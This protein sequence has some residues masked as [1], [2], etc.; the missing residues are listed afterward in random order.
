MPERRSTKN[1]VAE[2]KACRVAAVNSITPDA[3]MRRQLSVIPSETS[4]GRM[5]LADLGSRTRF[6]QSLQRSAGNSALL[7]STP[8]RP[9]DGPEIGRRVVGSS[10]PLAEVQRIPGV[11]DTVS[12]SAGVQR[13]P[14]GGAGGAPSA[15]SAA[16]TAAAR[17]EVELLGS[18]L[19]I[20]QMNL[21]SFL[22]DANSDITNIR[23]YFK[24]LNDVFARCHQHYALVIAQA[25]AEAQTEQAW[26]DFASGVA[27]GA[28]V[29]LISEAVIAGRA[30]EKAIESVTEVAAE[31]V[32]GGIGSFAK[33]DV[34]KPALSADLAPALKQVATLAKL[35]E[36]NAA[37]L[38]K[39]ISGLL[40]LDPIVQSERL[41][42]ELR[43]AEAGGARRMSDADVQEMHLRLMRFEVSSSQSD[44]V[45][46][47]AVAAFD[48]LRQRYMGLQPPSDERTEQD[49]W[50]PWITQQSGAPQLNVFITPVLSR[51]VL[52]NHLVD[53]GLARRGAPGGRLNADISQSRRRKP[54]DVLTTIEPHQQLIVGA[55]AQAPSIPSLWAKLL[56]ND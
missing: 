27:T 17:N 9:N 55:R 15:A 56:L 47:T 48:A 24:W 13:A 42:A 39:A 20:N 3:V 4:R 22:R 18:R 35:D 32:E 46:T 10:P 23:A 38:N 14:V 37:V 44:R 1:D 30:A 53:I 12:A 49:I 33:F 36:L 7:R 26:L 41:T 5:G 28:T 43:V 52:A 45:I 29:G 19:K 11:T 2:T 16:A 21:A 50:I 25:G 54:D 6:L 40:Y 8:V 31:F 34:P 51:T